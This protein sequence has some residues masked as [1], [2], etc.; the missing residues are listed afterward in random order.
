MPNVIYGQYPL[1][2]RFLVVVKIVPLKVCCFGIVTIV[3]H[4]IKIQDLGLSD[5]MATGQIKSDDLN[6]DSFHGD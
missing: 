4:M 3:P 5:F 2:A 6:E 1:Y